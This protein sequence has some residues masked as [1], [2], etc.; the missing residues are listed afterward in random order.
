MNAISQQFGRPTGLLG[1]LIGHLM[2]AKNQKRGEWVTSLLAVSPGERVLEVGFGPGADA[3]RVLDALGPSGFLMGV[4]ASEVM[5]EQAS[6]RNRAA[7]AEGR[8][9][10]M[11]GG[12]ESGLALED[13]RFDAAFAINCAQFWPSLEQ[14]LREMSRVLVRG[15]R[16]T[17][18]VQPMQRGATESDSARWADDLARAAR[19]AGLLNVETCLG[20]TNPPVA[21]VRARN[22]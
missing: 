20:P 11:R 16:L 21:A 9:R 2:A 3:R 12:I 22:G 7:V 1:A 19:S 14:G 8:A 5:V 15:G 6:K 4:D 13:A 18:A 10:F 17:V